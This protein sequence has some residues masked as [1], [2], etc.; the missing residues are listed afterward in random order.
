MVEIEE[1]QIVLHP[2]PFNTKQG[3]RNLHLIIAFGAWMNLTLQNMLVKKWFSSAL[4]KEF[5]RKPFRGIMLAFLYMGRQAQEN[6]S[7]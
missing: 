3:E 5:L 6:P 7:P 4:G 1:N 2:P